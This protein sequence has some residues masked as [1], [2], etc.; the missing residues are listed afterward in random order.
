M[1]VLEERRELLRDLGEEAFEDVALARAKEE[2]ENTELIRR[3]E[4]LKLLQ[5]QAQMSGKYYRIRAGEY[6]IG[7]VIEGTWQFLCGA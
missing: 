1:E 4:V 6:R 3:D 5:G 7:R 2:G